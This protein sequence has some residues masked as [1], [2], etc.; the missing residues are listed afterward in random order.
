MT[1]VEEVE[2][3]INV[4]SYKIAL[5]LIQKQSSPHLESKLQYYKLEQNVRFLGVIT[6]EDFRELLS[7]SLAFVQHSVTA[8]N[9]DMEGTPLTVMEAS[10]TGLP[11]VATL[12]AG[13]PDVIEH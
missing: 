10:S 7:E 5:D 12:H 1:I 9:G 3:L 11:V 2:S 13:I 8:L 4:G 6:A